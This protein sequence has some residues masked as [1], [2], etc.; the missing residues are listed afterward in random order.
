MPVRRDDA[1]R[2][3]VDVCGR[4]DPPGRPYA[5]GAAGA[6]WGDPPGR[7][8]EYPQR[9]GLAAMYAT[10]REWSASLRTMCS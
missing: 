10:M 7:P 4:G 8:Y 5:A 2:D 6:H 1:A 9:R 3:C